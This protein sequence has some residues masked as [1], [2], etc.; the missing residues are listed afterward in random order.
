[1]DAMRHPI[2]TPVPE[3]QGTTTIA[4]KRTLVRRLRETYSM[5]VGN[6]GEPDYD[7]P[8][9]EPRPY[10]RDGE[11]AAAHI[12]ALETQLAEAVVQMEAAFADPDSLKHSVTAMDAFAGALT[13]ARF[14]LALSCPRCGHSTDSEIHSF[15]CKERDDG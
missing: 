10:N 7:G 14:T 15:G 12:E 9:F 6:P 8:I 3:L 1:M 13:A 2:S 4:V 5:L 11:E